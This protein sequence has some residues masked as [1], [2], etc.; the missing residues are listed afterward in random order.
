L[1]DS[2]KKCCTMIA[3]PLLKAFIRITSKS[4][5]SR[6]RG[7]CQTPKA[8][9]Q[10]TGSARLTEDLPPPDAPSTNWHSMITGSP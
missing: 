9:A 8:A 2:R 3:W 5:A 7:M 1:A 10:R 4:P 6:E